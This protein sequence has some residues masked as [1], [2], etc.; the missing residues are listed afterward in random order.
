ML[1][2]TETAWYEQSPK[3]FHTLCHRLL[4]SWSYCMGFLQRS[5]RPHV[6]LLAAANVILLPCSRADPCM[7]PG[8]MLLGMVNRS[9]CAL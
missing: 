9:A 4:H 1:V 6:A 2:Q 3:S 8:C 5:M 7:V